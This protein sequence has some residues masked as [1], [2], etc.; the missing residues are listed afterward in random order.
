MATLYIQ[1]LLGKCSCKIWC[2]LLSKFRSFRLFIMKFLCWRTPY[3]ILTKFNLMRIPPEENTVKNASSM[4]TADLPLLIARAYY[5][6]NRYVAQKLAR[7][8]RFML[9]FSMKISR[10]IFISMKKDQIMLAIYNKI[11]L[12]IETYIIQHPFNFN[13]SIIYYKNEKNLPI[14][15]LNSNSNLIW[16]HIWI[17]GMLS[18]IEKA[19]LDLFNVMNLRKCWGDPDLKRIIQRMSVHRCNFFAYKYVTP[20]ATLFRNK[21]IEIQDV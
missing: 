5:F 9:T 2:N 14:P 17:F 16:D 11:I 21:A 12:S 10:I 19:F 20:G 3:N 6:R 7:F 1:E 18:K 15:S 13:L 8:S 4:A